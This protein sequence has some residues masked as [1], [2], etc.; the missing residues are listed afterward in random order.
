MFFQKKLEP[1][2]AC[3]QEILGIVIGLEKPSSDLAVLEKSFI[4]LKYH[5]AS[6]LKSWQDI[7]RNAEKIDNPQVKAYIGHIGSAVVQLKIDI[8]DVAHFKLESFIKL[9]YNLH[10][11]IERILTLLYH[12]EK[13][14]DNLEKKGE[15][16]IEVHKAESK[17]L[18]GIYELL[19]EAKESIKASFEPHIL[20]NLGHRLE[21]TFFAAKQHFMQHLPA[22]SAADFD[23]IEKKV[24]KVSAR[25]DSITTKFIT[26]ESKIEIRR[27]VNDLIKALFLFNNNLAQAI[28]DEVKRVNKIKEE[29]ALIGDTRNTHAA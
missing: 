8:E 25:F 5:A 15:M 23:D 13:F 10:N 19:I 6:M 12:F 3:V 2:S 22:V 7:E 29:E 9:K 26:E 21:D 28:K 20:Q 17:S 1:I 14:L 18:E 24:L 27:E 4:A 11:E 16:L